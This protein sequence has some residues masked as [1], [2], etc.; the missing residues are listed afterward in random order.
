M[1]TRTSQQHLELP[2]NRR[3]ENQS[4]EKSKQP[5]CMRDRTQNPD[6]EATPL[7]LKLDHRA[8]S[9]SNLNPRAKIGGNL[10]TRCSFCN[11]RGHRREVCWCL[12]PRL[13]PSS[14]R[15]DFRVN[16]P[17]WRGDRIGER[18]WRMQRGDERTCGT[19]R[20]GLV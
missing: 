4:A 6:Y 16:S 2:Q 17:F 18:N 8:L 19:G 10:T 11:K 5:T 20:T 14:V 13:W 12:N 15:Q 7:P 9:I 3:I 1:R